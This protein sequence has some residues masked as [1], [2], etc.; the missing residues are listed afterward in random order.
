MPYF[1]TRVEL[2]KANHDSE[3]Y[4]KLHAEMAKRGFKRTAPFNDG[5]HHL[6]TAEYWSEAA[7]GAYSQVRELAKAAADATGRTYSILVC[8][9][10]KSNYCGQ[11][12]PKA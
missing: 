5:E 3:Y 11:N 7:T 8:E 9:V 1:V 10:Y 2:H 6:P 12:L 4:T